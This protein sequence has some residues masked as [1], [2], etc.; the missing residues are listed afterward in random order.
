[1][2]LRVKTLQKPL[3]PLA[4]LDSDGVRQSRAVLGQLTEMEE[5]FMA[6]S[7]LL[8]Y[9]GGD[10]AYTSRLRNTYL[11]LANSH[12]LALLAKD[13]LDQA[14][15]LLEEANSQ[16][17]LGPPSLLAAVTASNLACY[18]RRRR[19]FKSALLHLRRAVDIEAQCHEPRGLADTQINMAVVLS[20]LGQH[21]SARQHTMQ[22]LRLIECE[23]SG[24]PVSS[25]PSDRLAVYVSAL[26]N[27]SVEQGFLGLSE[28]AESSRA[29]AWML[30]ESWLGAHHP[31]TLAIAAARE[32][33]RA[34]TAK[35]KRGGRSTASE[36][37]ISDEGSAAAAAAI[38]GNGVHVVRKLQRPQ[39][40]DATQP[41][42]RA[43][44]PASGPG[45]SGMSSQVASARSLPSA[46]PST[47]SAAFQPPMF[48]QQPRA[49]RPA[50]MATMISSLRVP[51]PTMEPNSSH[52]P[53]H[54]SHSAEAMSRKRADMNQAL[55]AARL[56]ASRRMGRAKLTARARERSTSRRA[57]SGFIRPPSVV[58]VQGRMLHD[59]YA[60]TL[61][62]YAPPVAA[63][64]PFTDHGVGPWSYSHDW[65]HRAVPQAAAVLLPPGAAF[66]PP[67]PILGGSL[68]GGSFSTVS[69]SSEERDRVRAETLALV[70]QQVEARLNEVSASEEALRRQRQAAEQAR[71]EAWQRHQQAWLATEARLQE[72][73]KAKAKELTEMHARARAEEEASIAA[74]KLAV[75][76]DGA[77]AAHVAAELATSPLT[78]PL[79]P[80]PPS[81]QATA[82]AMAQACVEADAAE[83]AEALLHER[84]EREERRP[85]REEGEGTGAPTVTSVTFGPGS[86]SAA[87]T[88]APEDYSLA[89]LSAREALR[90]REEAPPPTPQPASPQPAP[91]QPALEADASMVMAIERALA[92]AAAAAM[93]AEQAEARS[94]RLEQQMQRLEEQM[95]LPPHS[96][97]EHVPSP[98]HQPS[99][100]TTTMPP[101]SDAPLPVMRPPSSPPMDAALAAACTAFESGEG[102][103]RPSP[104]EAQLPLSLINSEPPPSLVNSEPP[105]SLINSDAPP[106]LKDSEPPPSL[107]NSEPPSLVGSEPPTQP[108]PT[109]P[110]QPAQPAPQPLQAPA[111]S[112]SSRVDR[113]LEGAAVRA[114]A[115]AE[116][117]ERAA[118]AVEAAAVQAESEAAREVAMAKEQSDAVAAVC[119]TGFDSP[120]GMAAVEAAEAAKKAAA[121][122]RVAAE[123]VKF[124]AYS[125]LLSA[126]SQ[127]KAAE[128]KA[129]AA[130]RVAA[131]EQAAA[132]ERKAAER[133]AA[134]ERAAEERA[135]AE[136][137]A[138]A[139][140]EK[141][142]AELKAAAQSLAAAKA[143]SEKAAALRVE[144]ATAVARAR[145]ERADGVMLL[146]FKGE[147]G[148]EIDSIAKGAP[149]WQIDPNAFREGGWVQVVTA[150][151][152]CGSVPEEF[153]K[154]AERDATKEAPPAAL[155]TPRRLKPKSAYLEGLGREDRAAVLIA[156]ASRGMLGRS[157]SFYRRMELQQEEGLE[158]QEEEPQPQPKALPRTAPDGSAMRVLLALAEYTAQP[159]S[160]EVSLSTGMR[161]LQLE[162][163][164]DPALHASAHHG[165]TTPLSTGMRLLQLE[166][167]D[168]NGWVGV[169]PLGAVSPL[170]Q[171]AG[172]APAT[173]LA[174]LEPDG[175][176]LLDF[177]LEGDSELIQ[178]AKG[179]P[180]WIGQIDP[181]AFREGG[182]VQVV[183]AEGR[184]GSVPEEFVKW[185]ERD[186]TKEA[187]PA[188][189][190]TPRR[191]KPKSAYLEGLGRE[192][193]AAVLIASASR[194]MLGRSESFYRRMELQQEEGLETQEEEPQPQPQAPPRTAPDGSARGLE[195]EETYRLPRGADVLESGHST[196]SYE[197]RSVLEKQR[198]L[199]A[200]QPVHKTG[201]M[202]GFGVFEQTMVVQESSSRPPRALE[203]RVAEAPP[204]QASLHASVQPPSRR[205]S[206]ETVGEDELWEDYLEQ[207][208]EDAEAWT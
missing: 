176:M 74:A 144:A 193:R 11:E 168:A 90:F 109:Q 169:A 178:I 112:L 143:A 107:I 180:L 170:R 50:P 89:A 25:L 207:A 49:Q 69:L 77:E 88:S 154:W 141:A 118:Q 153:V 174:V 26:H 81:P 114:A 135:A 132:A 30:A 82:E 188:A 200:E 41:K 113:P 121:A 184:C 125:A 59:P 14:F 36:I 16:A 182:W 145:A 165:A 98:T 116:A 147:G 155:L 63:P 86:S 127:Q 148:G 196:G 33:I 130:E 47:L 203:I 23:A 7:A 164:M 17:E 162:P 134:A 28:E 166:P 146:D 71:H 205:G 142:S 73:S 92:A 13:D 54:P 24:A 65:L 100:A 119:A 4:F 105:P 79:R 87:S 139:A 122:E 10:S 167:P 115:R 48:S 158:T 131:E 32:T 195:A 42:R 97:H 84:L 191:L 22:A 68:S 76:Q 95:L 171:A 2:R 201:A 172:F 140:E 21:D 80:R 202:S 96:P 177:E 149:V 9:T 190:L 156:S 72:E 67:G 18:Y 136:R 117:A 187:P 45:S 64:S 192:D 12:A 194:G 137:A 94:R 150:E 198:V 39:S 55:E 110:A 57:R 34:G 129:A 186:A 44:S 175:V 206:F 204:E 3:P 93:R 66:A 133:K 20:E 5:L 1:M 29:T 85:E 173:Y 15:K 208:A 35:K 160:E 103:L 106:S 99:T 19:K 102:S 189:L 70:R 53:S 179:T 120:G 138:I 61:A 6:R 62:P 108:A 183:T 37:E 60:L 152:R 123:R 101:V 78:S 104:L 197:P 181:N 185:A 31:V 124:A 161:L 56:E 58:P 75:L 51:A 27:L 8:Q 128:E 159:D 52:Q 163:N 157:E 83:T 91:Q 151:G 126:R 111:I 40:S 199:F 46:A 43:P 38:G